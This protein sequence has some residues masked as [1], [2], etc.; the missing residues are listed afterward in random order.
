MNNL[1]ISIK[2]SLQCTSWFKKLLYFYTNFI[3]HLSYHLLS[4]LIS[5]FNSLILIIENLQAS[6]S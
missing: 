6:I 4:C 5:F 2:E 3:M 1:I